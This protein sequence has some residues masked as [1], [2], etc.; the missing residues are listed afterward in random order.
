MKMFNMHLFLEIFTIGKS[1]DL[2][3]ELL[4]AYFSF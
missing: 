4:I 3:M 2:D 1:L